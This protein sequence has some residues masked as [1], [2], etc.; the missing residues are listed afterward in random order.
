[1]TLAPIAARPFAQ[2][3]ARRPCAVI[4]LAAQGSESLHWRCADCGLALGAAALQAYPPVQGRGQRGGVESAGSS[5]ALRLPSRAHRHLQAGGEQQQQA[6][7]RCRRVRSSEG[8]ALEIWLLPW[9]RVSGLAP[10]APE[11]RGAGGL[12]AGVPTAL[13]VQDQ[14]CQ[15]PQQG[16]L[17]AAAGSGRRQPE[18]L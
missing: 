5:A 7:S 9:V 4:L 17:R 14:P 11:A 3:A 12:Q 1:V 13:G 2:F 10:T 18:P 8:Q 15:F 6:G 16:V